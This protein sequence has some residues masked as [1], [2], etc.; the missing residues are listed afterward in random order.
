MYPVHLPCL[1]EGWG[2]VERGDLRGKG[3]RRIR[4]TDNKDAGPWFK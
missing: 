3:A 2:W 4:G 1:N